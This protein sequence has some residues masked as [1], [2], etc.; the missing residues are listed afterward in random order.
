MLLLVAKVEKERIRIRLRD[1][2]FKEGDCLAGIP[3][4]LTLLQLNR[5][6]LH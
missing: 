3:L 5:V 6:A 1:R 4:A 2:E